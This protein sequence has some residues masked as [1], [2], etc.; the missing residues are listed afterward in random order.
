[1][2]V[3]AVIQARTGSSRLPGKVLLE[4]P[5]GSGIT[6]LEQVIDRVK[7]AKS[8]QQ[9]VVATTEKPEDDR[10]AEIA[11]GAGVGV[12]RGSERDVLARYYGAAKEYG[13]DVVVRITSDC[14]CTDP[15]I[16]DR[17]VGLHLREGADYTA[18]RGFPRGFDVEVIS[19]RALEEAHKNATEPFEREHVCPYIYTTA[20]ERFKILYYDA[21]PEFAR[22][23][24]RVT[25]DT[26]ED[27]ALLCCVFDNLYG[28][29]PFFGVREVVALFDKKP[30][31]GI[32]NKRIRQK[33]TLFTLEEELREAVEVLKLQ[34]LRRA[35]RVLEDYLENPR[36]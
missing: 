21:P 10:I 12:F 29:N 2:R 22:P 30:Y 35:A 24:I 5:Y 19:L 13:L 20:P 6:V 36:R 34:E 32:I 8:L 26:E 28:E 14:P 1:M 33:R 18:T 15:E 11:R 31:L 23:D 25:L 3:G 7:R 16:I 9:V 27:Y 4:L 17:V